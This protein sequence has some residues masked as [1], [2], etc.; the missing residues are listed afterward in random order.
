MCNLIIKMI[1]ALTFVG[2][3]MIIT[4]SVVHASLAINHLTHILIVLLE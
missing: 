3:E 2:C 1:I 4:N